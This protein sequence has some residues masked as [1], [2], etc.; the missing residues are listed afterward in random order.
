[1]KAKAEIIKIYTEKIKQL[2]KHN[3]LYFNEDNPSISDSKYDNL[4]KEITNL[5]KKKYIFERSKYL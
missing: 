3:E 5:E 2:E 4:K 1:M